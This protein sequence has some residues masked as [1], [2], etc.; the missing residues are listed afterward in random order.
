VRAVVDDVI[1][2]V[3]ADHPLAHEAA[4]RIGKHGEDGVDVALLDE[5]RE[6][7]ALE[8]SRHHADSSVPDWPMSRVGRLR[9]GSSWPFC[10]AC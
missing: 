2:E 5:L 10:A 7:L 9:K 3:T 6:S 8:P 1:E 4:E